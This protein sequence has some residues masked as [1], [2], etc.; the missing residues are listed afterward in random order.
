MLKMMKKITWT[1][2]ATLLCILTVLT[3]LCFVGCKKDSGGDTPPNTEVSFTLTQNVAEI[4]LDETLQLETKMV[5]LTGTVVWESENEKIVTVSNGLVT[6]VSEGITTV[7]ASLDGYSASC[8]IRVYNSQTAPTLTLNASA[9]TLG[10]GETFTMQTSVSYKG[11]D[12]SAD[13]TYV[14]TLTENG[15]EGIAALTPDGK[16]AVVEGVGYGET[17]YVVAVT[18][19]GLTLTETFTVLVR[20]AGIVLDIPQ[21]TP[22][23][24][25]GYT[26]DLYTTDAGGYYK[27][28]PITVTVYDNGTIVENAQVEF[29]SE[30]AAIAKVENGMLIGLDE[31]ATNVAVQYNGAT[32]NVAVSVVKP[33]FALSQKAL[34]EVGDLQPIKT[35]EPLVGD[36]QD[37]TVA[38]VS[39]YSAYSAEEGLSLSAQQL[40]TLAV[41]DYGENRV[42]SIETTEAFYDLTA[43]IYSLV[44]ETVEDYAKWGEISL[45]A[46]YKKDGYQYWGGYFIMN[47]N[48]SQEGGIPMN[49]FIERS[50]PAIGGPNGDKGGFV[51]V[52]DGR[53][54]N[55]DG[56]YKTDTACRSAFIGI[57]SAGGVLKNVSFTNAV[58]NDTQGCFI[59]F[60]GGKATLE[61]LYISYAEIAN[62]DTSANLQGA[63][64]FGGN[65]GGVVT[66]NCFVD[67]S[68]AKLSGNGYKFKIIGKGEFKGLGCLYPAD[69]TSVTG[70]A[71]GDPW[72]T[73]CVVTDIT[74]MQNDADYQTLLSK[75]DSAFW[76]VLNGVPVPKKLYEDVYSK[77]D[78]IGLTEKAPTT[79]EQGQSYRIWADRNYVILS[80]DNG[81]KAQGNTLQ[82][83]ENTT[84]GTEITVTVTSAFNSNNALTFKMTVVEPEPEYVAPVI[85]LDVQV[86][87]GVA[88]LNEE[89]FSLTVGKAD[90]E[91]GNVISVLFGEKELDA[92][93]FSVA[94][95]VVSAPLSVFGFDIY[96]TAE[97]FLGFDSG[98]IAQF[99]DTT[100]ITKV[101]KTVEDYQNW[102][103]I[104]DAAGYVDGAYQYWD[105]Y[106]QLGANLSA[107]GGIAL[108]EGITR[109]MV[110]SASGSAGGFAGIFDGCGYTIDGLIKNSNAKS[111]L[112]GIMAGGTLKNI[113]LTNAVFNGSQGGLITF[114]G[115]GTYEDIYVSYASVSGVVEGYY[116]GT[117]DVG[118][119]GSTMRRI[120]VS[121]ENTV[122]DESSKAN[123][124]LVGQGRFAEGL[125]GVDNRLTEALAWPNAAYTGPSLMIDSYVRFETASALF[126]GYYA[127]TASSYYAAVSLWETKCSSWTVVNGVPVFKTK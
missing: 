56:L 94:N 103:I 59:T 66:V 15:T 64:F 41:S 17:E 58:F 97:L 12:I 122:W 101:I 42:L 38:G 63:T 87:D 105:G 51:G 49:Q 81:V 126:A 54:Y 84:I 16:N 110:G 22:V 45:A 74:E 111:G 99:P 44:I 14:W 102:V 34:V 76:T 4:D 52:F 5:N 69:A 31:G 65:N 75:Y 21:L 95:G 62:A 86:V 108:N 30:N 119:S 29:I 43:D 46:G 73:R 39:V 120:F 1:M 19:K 57:L 9:V 8:M 71:G 48:L 37:V 20:D 60:G 90:E 27:S 112:I 36:V 91:F 106:F 78:Q 18:A 117:F 113:A 116:A 115:T 11:E 10:K 92:S 6:P 83:P 114:A 61:N 82:I 104:A 24:G 70:P 67:A 127:N 89:P 13:A 121:A 107:E 77:E 40:N 3:A 25:G 88:T 32:V 98:N 124:D 79:V 26:T 118:N 68:N 53:G 85:N 100:V 72:G 125:Y 47:A 2:K 55:I 23:K 96:G 123:F 80:A 109:D 28:M 35:E 93:K 7:T 33:T 50:N